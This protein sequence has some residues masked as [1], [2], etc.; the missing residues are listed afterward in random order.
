MHQA[1]QDRREEKLAWVRARW[2]RRP[3]P[4]GIRITRIGLWY[5]LFTVL[6]A[7]AAT[8]TGNNALYLVLAFQL[9]LLVLSGWTSRRNVEGLE[10]ELE[11]P[12]EIFAGSPVPLRF[13]LRNRS[14][15]FS[16][17]LL[18]LAL[19]PGKSVN[20]V[21]VLPARSVAGGALD[22]I[23]PRRG[24]TRLDEVWVQSLFPLGL[25]RKGCRYPIDFEV[26]VYPQL[27]ESGRWEKPSLEAESGSQPSNRR[28]WGHE[29]F[30]L[31]EFQ[32]GDDP[33]SIHWK[34]TAQLDTLVV[35]ERDSEDQRFLT[36]VV[37]NATGRL[38]AEGRRQFE[39]LV[40]EAATA[41]VAKL[42]EGYTVALVTRSGSLPA[43]AG[44]V[45]RRAIL[46]H[47]ALLEPVDSALEPLFPRLW[48]GALLRFGLTRA[49]EAA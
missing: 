7:T 30:A 12:A 42:R 46:E 33:R 40:S 4:G 11:K 45:Q 10:A 41:A 24:L 15:W 36:V 35:R 32:A 21:P 26:L 16:K 13:R 34:K 20:L 39:R 29:L 38:D 14:R 5:V 2:R 31:R 9:A 17:R 49:G 23:F 3:L 19:Q 18:L 27:Y 28:G 6:V 47:L 44:M 8:N 48:R 22:W 43:G 25:F 37:D 1:K